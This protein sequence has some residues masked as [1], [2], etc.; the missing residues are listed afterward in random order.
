MGDQQTTETL[1]GILFD[2]IEKVRS[3]AIDYQEAKAIGDLA[4]RIIKT[5][6]LELK[7]AATVSRLDAEGQGVTQGPMMLANKSEGG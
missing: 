2:T 6:D 1:R 7:H 3:R 4:D 5:A